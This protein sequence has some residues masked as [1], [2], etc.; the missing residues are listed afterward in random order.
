[1]QENILAVMKLWAKYLHKILQNE[2]EQMSLISVA[3]CFHAETYWQA[4][5]YYYMIM[6]FSKIPSW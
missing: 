3:Q 1:M 6:S 5:K 2:K 4:K